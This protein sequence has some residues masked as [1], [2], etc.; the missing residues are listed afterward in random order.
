MRA[1]C[2]TRRSQA[3]AAAAAGMP[4]KFDRRLCCPL[5]RCNREE[6]ASARMIIIDPSLPIRT[7]MPRHLYYGFLIYV[8]HPPAETQPRPAPAATAS[9]AYN[10]VFFCLFQRLTYTRRARAR[11]RDRAPRER[12]RFLSL[13]RSSKS[14]SRLISAL[15]REREPNDPPVRLASVFFILFFQIFYF[16]FFYSQSPRRESIPRVLSRQ[17]R[18]G[19]STKSERREE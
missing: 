13:D 11:E 2:T 1:V 6:T 16:F 12:S 9:A 15:C 8:P 3:A 18:E 19:H 10:N 14:T 4:R 5:T 17:D 7:A